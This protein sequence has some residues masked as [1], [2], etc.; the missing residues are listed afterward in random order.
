MTGSTGEQADAWQA[1]SD[2]IFSL[3]FHPGGHLLASASRGRDIKLWD[4]RPN[5]K[6]RNLITLKGH[7]SMV[8]SVCFS[9]D[10][11]TL[12]SGSEDKLVGLWDLTYYQRH[13]DG[14]R[15]HQL[16]RL[17]ASHGSNE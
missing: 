13:I 9:P 7:Q 3:S 6:E 12:A 2:D 15:D 14:N 17:V 11:R 5:T 16:K 4:A 1:H 8:F 10:G